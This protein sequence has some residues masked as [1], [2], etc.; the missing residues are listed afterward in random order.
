MKSNSPSSLV[1]AFRIRK[2]L[3]AALGCCMLAGSAL[4]QLTSSSLEGTVIDSLG[5]PIA[6]VT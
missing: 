1:H 2:L 6:G 5:N 3:A 4:G